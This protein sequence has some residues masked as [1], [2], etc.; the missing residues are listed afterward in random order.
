[1]IFSDR[2]EV[3]R[4]LS[5][6]YQGVPN[7]VTVGQTV[8][9]DL[10]VT[11]IGTGALQT[12]ALQELF[13]ENLGVYSAALTDTTWTCS[14]TGDAVC[15][16]G[17]GTGPLRFNEMNAGGIDL[18]V[19]DSL[20][21][22]IER[23][24]DVDSITGEVIHL[25]AGTVADPVA[26][27]ATFSVAEAQMTVIGESAGLNIA[28]STAT[29]DSAATSGDATDDAQITVTVLDSSQNPVPGEPV[30][31]DDA[32]GLNVTSATSGT[33]DSSGE[34]SFTAT[35]EEAGDYTIS[36]TSG[37]LNGSGVVTIMAGEP[38][39]FFTQTPV[40]SAVADG[41]SEVEVQ[42]LIEDQFGNAVSMALVEVTND[43]GLASL[44]PE[45]F[46]DI[47]GIATFNATSTTVGTYEPSFSVPGVGSSSATVSFDPGAPDDLE[48][49]LQP[50]DPVI[51]GVEFDVSLIVVDAEDNLV[52]DDQDTFVTLNLQQG[53]STVRTLTSGSVDNGQITFTVD[54][55][56]QSD[57]G[58]DYRIQ[59][60]AS[61]TGFFG[62][63]STTFDIVAQ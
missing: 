14:A 38:D 21:F 59:A 29:A 11:N 58:T 33:S 47:A 36:F 20:T 16:A 24:V 42:F 40:P 62:A 31:L 2:L 27:G 45:A 5:L 34:V 6:E 44:P 22:N 13:P 60:V 25:H 32:G 50:P 7:F 37:S 54:T 52:T 46:T 41:Q 53:G 56:G 49:T 23:T 55:I 63:N 28:S 1:M 57:V 9:Y 35:A 30:S 3:D 48:F 43:D 12:T 8:N 17:S 19:G 15:P 18:T 51:E 10:V 39:S 4:E 61:G 26:T